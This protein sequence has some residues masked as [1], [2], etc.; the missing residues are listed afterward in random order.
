MTRSIG[1]ASLLRHL[2]AWRGEGARGAA[3]AQLADAIRL[4]ILDGRLALDVRL[5][6]ERELAAALGVSRTTVTAAFTRLRDQGFLVSRQGSGARTGLPSGP[7]LR[8]GASLPLGSGEGL[9]DLSSAAL[10]AAEGVHAAY[11]Q[12]L[13]ALPAHLPGHGYEATGLPVLREVIAERYGRSGLPTRP[14]QIV[15]T[16]GAQ[17]GLTLLL[18]MFTGPGDRVVVDQPTYPHAIDAIQRVSCRPAPVP[19]PDRG[20]D[21]DGL[22]AAFRQNGP[23]LAYLI[24]DFHNP[25][26]RCMEPAARAEVAAAA[27]RTRT[28]L[29]FDETMSDLWLDAPPP[30]PD[31]VLERG[32]IRLGSMGK[33][34]WGG[35]RIGWIRA[36]AEVAAALVASR[37][38]LDLG[39]PVLEQL[40]AAVLLA[41]DVGLDARRALL[42]E[43]RE[44]LLARMA[45]RLPEWRITPPSGGLVAWAELPGPVSTALAAA[46][47]RHGVRITPGPRFGVDGTLERFVRLPYSQP[48]EVLDAAVEGLARA[49]A[50]LGLGGAAPRTSAAQ[51]ADPVV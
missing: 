10:P 48:P 34:F 7:G 20:W 22:A 18:R 36:D 5:P 8:P 49:W 47:E 33:S 26:G 4:L 6:G 31:P 28:A 44:H 32:V 39:T 25:T 45:E 16:S 50:A 3:Y 17:H 37:P 46:A 11:A 27:A 29:V 15:V 24:A 21:L 40:A 51:G 2:G 38:S 43:R 42:R 1:T 14:D 19:L 23:R 30:A 41:E 9:I 35:L 13:A 12:A